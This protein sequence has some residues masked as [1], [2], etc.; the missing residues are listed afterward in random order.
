MRPTKEHFGRYGEGEFRRLSESAAV[1][2]SKQPSFCSW[3]ALFSNHR[4]SGRNANGIVK[5][6]LDYNEVH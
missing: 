3:G 1:V 2:I 5:Q 4:Y 6:E